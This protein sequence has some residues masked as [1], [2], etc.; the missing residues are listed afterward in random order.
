[1]V[2]LPTMSPW[3]AIQVKIIYVIGDRK[4]LLERSW[5]RRVGSSAIIARSSSDHS[6]KDQRTR[7]PLDTGAIS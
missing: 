6:R 7:T 1:M 5:Q 2:K 4:S 3:E